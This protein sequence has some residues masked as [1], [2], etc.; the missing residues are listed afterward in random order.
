MTGMG[1]IEIADDCGAPE[2]NL[3]APL[4]TIVD[5]GNIDE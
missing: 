4:N 1:D 2:Y 5:C 3:V